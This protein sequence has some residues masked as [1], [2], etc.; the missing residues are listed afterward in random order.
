MASSLFV[1]KRTRLLLR[2][3]GDHEVVDE[4]LPAK[5]RLIRRQTSAAPLF[6]IAFLPYLL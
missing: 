6:L 3:K 5:S 4:E 1:V 2:E